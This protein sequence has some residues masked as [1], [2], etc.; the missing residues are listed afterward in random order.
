MISNCNNLSNLLDKLSD[1]ELIKVLSYL[2]FNDLYKAG[3][4]FKRIWNLIKCNQSHLLY[5]LYKR[6]W[7][8][9]IAWKSK[10]NRSNILKFNHQ[11]QFKSE[12]LNSFNNE[13]TY[14]CSQFSRWPIDIDTSLLIKGLEDV[15]TLVPD[16]ISTCVSYTGMYV[17]IL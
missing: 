16:H 4:A 1:D 10:I 13:I 15:T 7:Y 5:S 8:K 9:T 17:C 12:S 6:F 3:I 2:W 11:I 14:L